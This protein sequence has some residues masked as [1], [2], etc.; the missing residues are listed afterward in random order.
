M[1]ASNSL[2]LLISQSS[3]Y[4]KGGTV[5]TENFLKQLGAEIEKVIPNFKEL[6]KATSDSI[7]RRRVKAPVATKAAPSAT[8]G[9]GKEVSMLLPGISPIVGIL[10]NIASRLDTLAHLPMQQQ[11]I[12]AASQAVYKTVA[13]AKVAKAPRVKAPRLPK[14]PRIPKPR[15]RKPP[16]YK[17]APPPLP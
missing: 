1:P 16:T 11:A 7:S 10:G 13:T 14:A 5:E 9:L 12:S 4:I 17:L 8:K 3:E 15:G 6:N 2:I